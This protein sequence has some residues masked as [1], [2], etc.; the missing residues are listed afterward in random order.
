MINLHYYLQS[1]SGSS[2]LCSFAERLWPLVTELKNKLQP[3][4]EALDAF[5]QLVF[6]PN[7]LI[8]SDKEVVELQE[9]VSAFD[10]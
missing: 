3:F 6:H 10:I 7:L 5:I 4:N 2:L 8:S 9:N 1:S